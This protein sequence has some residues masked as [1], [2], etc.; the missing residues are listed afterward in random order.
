[1]KIRNYL[2]MAF[3][4]LVLLGV[5][6]VL[7]I[8]NSQR[9]MLAFFEEEARSFLT[10][11]AFTHEN[12]IFSEAELEDK[13]T[14][15]LLNMISYLH[16]YGYSQGNLDKIRQNF[17]LNSIIIY[18]NIKK[19]LIMK[20][21]SPYDIDLQGFEHNEKIR[22]YYFTVLNEKFIR[23]IY[24]TDKEIFQIE[25]SA[26]EIRQFSQEYGVG[27][28]L[29]QMA[30]N[31]LIQYVVLQDLQG[32][33]IATPNVRTMP[34]IESDS[35]MLAAYNKREEIT[36]IIKF[37]EKKVLEIAR[38]FV[39][40]NNIVGLFRIGLNLDNYYQHI[41]NTYLQLT[42]IFIILLIT[43]I[44]VFA[45][46]IKYQGYQ[47][48]EQFFSLILGAIE[49]GVLLVDDKGKITGVNKMFSMITDMS[50]EL[51]L[52]QYYGEKFKDDPFS[53][54]TVRGCG[55]FVEEEREMFGKI[56]QYATYPLL[57]VNKKITGTI[58]IL[59]D[60]TKIRKQEREQ[61]ERERLSFLGNL[62][63]NFAHEI[64][65]PLN[66]LAIAAQRLQ[67]EFPSQDEQYK[68]L[69]TVMIRE[70]DSMTRILND[71]LSL[72]RP[73]IK[74]FQEFN[75]GKLIEEVGILIKEQTGEKGIKYSEEI[76]GDVIFAGNREDI[77]RVIMN[78]LLNAIEAVAALK[79][80]KPE[81]RIA[82]R[83]ERKNIFIT[84]SDNGS[85]IP[86]SEL[87]KI[88]EPY[89][90]TKKG[91]TGLGLFIAQKIVREHNGEI[92]VESSDG[93]GT[94]FSIILPR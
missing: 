74:E 43:G 6:F 77:K 44:F 89:Y 39:V 64:K 85:G 72:V 33:I 53:L 41:R 81:I 42:L 58:S 67:R 75:L 93:F 37:G 20:S 66:G 90:T 9:S 18:D 60:V 15:N 82:L 30:G 21:G 22:Y 48:H 31:P 71:F 91:G 62:V 50:E 38:P 26:E 88:F 32:I 54:K 13:I 45:M 29:Q 25:L 73:Q 83:E 17:N 69:T 10:L 3:I 80:R 1:M 79:E 47:I 7:S 92:K 94:K 23:F 56:I 61:K 84:I 70:I 5:F 55:T 46:F 57:D 16:E 87:E 36:R 59:H 4:L 35:V 12:S 78:L 2:L 34:R 24:K 14:G 19:H 8:R 68:K 65:N 49:E 86:G 11:I 51:L 52:N 76:E 40:E 28:I 63:A 27:K